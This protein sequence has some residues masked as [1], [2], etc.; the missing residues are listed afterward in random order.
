MSE[1]FTL[2]TPEAVGIAYE[3]AGIG[4]RFLAQ[5][6]DTLVMGAIIIA[7]VLG[8]VGLAQLGDVG[9]NLAVI[10]ALTGGTILLSGGYF[11]LFETFWSGQTP[12]KRARKIRV[13]K[14]SGYPIGFTDAVVRNLVRLI[15]WL[16][17][18]YGVGIVSMF[19]SL[20]SRRLGDYA[21]GTIVVKERPRVALADLDSRS[22]LSASTVTP[23]LGQTDPDE[24]QWNLRA[25]QSDELSVIDEFLARAAS[26]PP[27]VRDRIGR[28]IA[29]RVALHLGARQPL[30]PNEFL[31]RVHHLANSDGPARK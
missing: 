12:G 1:Q 28:E 25:L 6:V 9:Q 24:L 23:A 4:T 19:V 13:L 3:I 15:D 7:L 31:E 27:P 30:D 10:I 17:F 20:Q 18:F 2:E 29:D 26:L 11:I 21:A 8:A 16:P 22:R 14:V 5:F